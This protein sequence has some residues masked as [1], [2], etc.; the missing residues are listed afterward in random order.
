MS[1]PQETRPDRLRR[2]AI[3]HLERLQSEGVWGLDLTAAEGSPSAD[4]PH[5]S[6]AGPSQ[7]EVEL[8][9]PSSDDQVELFAGGGS[10]QGGGPPADETLEQIEAEALECV[11]CRLHEGRNKV[12]FGVG[13]PKARLLF[14]GEGPGRDEDL[15]GEPFVGRAGKL[16]TK[17]IVAMGY[18]RKDVYIANVVKCR[19]PQNRNPQADEAGACEHFLLRQV[20]V[21]Q[22]Q[23]IVLLGKVAV[24]AILGT[25]APMSRLRGKF[26]TWR[27]IPVMC[28]YHPAYLLRNPNAKKDVWEDMQIVRDALAESGRP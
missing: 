5:V 3:E 26:Q 16:L 21:I 11:A 15:Q 4:S 8:I 20:A 18:E 22:P 12:V 1:P 23:I 25:S 14:I 10:G 28:T 7:Q 9:S 2:R 24:Q 6:G 17:I 19:P 27:G 13:S